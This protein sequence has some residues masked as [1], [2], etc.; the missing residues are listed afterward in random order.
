MLYIARVSTNNDQ[1]QTRSSIIQRTPKFSQPT[2]FFLNKYPGFNS[3][4][5]QNDKSEI[6]ILHYGSLA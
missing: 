6:N 3:P 1:L 2:K 4:G 5:N